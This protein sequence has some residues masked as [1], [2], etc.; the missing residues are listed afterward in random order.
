[1]GLSLV[2][3]EGWQ[4][5]REEGGRWQMGG[6]RLLTDGNQGA[7]DAES[8]SCHVMSWPR[9][10]PRPRPPTT[11]PIRFRGLTIRVARE[12]E[13]GA[14]KLASWHSGKLGHQRRRSHRSQS[15]WTRGITGL[16]VLLPTLIAGSPGCVGGAVTALLSRWTC[17]VRLH[18]PLPKTGRPYQSCAVLYLRV[19]RKSK[20]R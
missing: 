5:E 17:Q 3:G 12:G 7:S 13:R 11:Q 9:P 16:R 19:V 8:R 10:R 4:V 18:S 14:G 1:L 15:R 20:V 2:I 6:T